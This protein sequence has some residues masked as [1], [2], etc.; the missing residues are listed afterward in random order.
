MLLPW[1]PKLITAL[2]D[3]AGEFAP[4]LVREAGRTF[5]G[6]LHALDNW[7]PP[8]AQSPGQADDVEWVAPVGGPA[9]ELL[10]AYPES[11]NATAVL[12]G[13]GSAWRE[14]AVAG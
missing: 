11:C 3:Q 12:L 13:F 1:L 2:R 5:P 7:V 6:T 9:A 14:A 10:A 8:W 4:L